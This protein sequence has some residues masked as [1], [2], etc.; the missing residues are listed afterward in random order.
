MIPLV[1]LKAQYNSIKEEILDSSQA[2]GSSP[3]RP[4]AKRS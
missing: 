1:D 3:V 2:A 4:A